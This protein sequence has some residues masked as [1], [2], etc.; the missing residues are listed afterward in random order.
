[1]PEEKTEHQKLMDEIADVIEKHGY[2]NLGY[3]QTL[4]GCGDEALRFIKDRTLV[5]VVTE[6]EIDEETYK[7]VM[8]LDDKEE[9]TQ[10]GISSIN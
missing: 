1:M 4:P 2:K 10:S 9:T 6:F 5:D 8:Q 3:Q 7:L